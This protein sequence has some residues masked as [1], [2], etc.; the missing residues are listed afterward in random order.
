MI[1]TKDEA[2]PPPL[3]YFRCAKAAS[4]LSSLKSSA[5]RKFKTRIHDDEDEEKN[6]MMMVKEIG[7]LKIKLARERIKSKRIKLCSITEVI[8]QIVLALSFFV[9]VLMIAFSIA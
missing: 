4:I 3:K 7:D 9:V 2:L 8:L 6:L 1:G 5:N